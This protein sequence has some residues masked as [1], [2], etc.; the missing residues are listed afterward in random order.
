MQYRILYDYALNTGK[1]YRQH[2]EMAR[3]GALV[4]IWDLHLRVNVLPHYRRECHEPYE[5]M[6]KAELNLCATELLVYYRN[7]LDESD[8]S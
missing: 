7:H 2:C 8:G 1:F 4:R 3:E 6:S 5:G